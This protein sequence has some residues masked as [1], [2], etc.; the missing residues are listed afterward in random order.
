MHH[1]SVYLFVCQSIHSSIYPLS[2]HL[3][4][5]I[6]IHPSVRPSIH[7]AHHL[8][9]IWL[10]HSKA[11]IW[12]LSCSLDLGM[13][14]RSVKTHTD[15]ALITLSSKHHCIHVM[16]YHV[17]ATNTHVCSTHSES[18]IRSSHGSTGWLNVC[19]CVL[20]VSSISASAPHIV[21]ERK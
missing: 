8:G 12:F 1:A 21:N 4:V 9:G 14:T 10:G 16:A 7:P 13:P 5:H 6:F 19:V 2:I 3:C 18:L 20:L 17:S 15:V 11:F